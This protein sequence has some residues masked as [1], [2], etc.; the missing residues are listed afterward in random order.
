[1]P[2]F[3]MAFKVDG[4]VVTGEVAGWPADQALNPWDDQPQYLLNDD[5][6]AGAPPAADPVQAAAK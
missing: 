2:P 4:K 1:M 6:T 5:L 3:F